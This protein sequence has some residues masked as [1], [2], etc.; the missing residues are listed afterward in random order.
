[1]NA[2]N[3]TK[4]KKALGFLI[5]GLLFF[6]AL[7]GI[8]RF[9]TRGPRWLNSNYV[10]MSRG[11]PELEALIEDS[12]KVPQSPKYYDEFLYAASPVSTRYITFTDYYSARLTPA[13]VPL[14]QAEH[15]IWTFGGSTMENTETTDKLS[16]ANTWAKIFNDALGP[17]HVKNFGSGGFNSTF[18]LVK[19]QKL[20]REGR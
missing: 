14:S 11:F 19:F 15:I 20:L 3:L 6:L 2:S 12:Q 8:A 16:I 7:E 10:E 9:Q 13:S 5:L 4:G 1:M 18:E 17:T